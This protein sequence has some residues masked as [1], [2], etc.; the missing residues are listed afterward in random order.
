LWT[1]SERAQAAGNTDDTNWAPVQSALAAR[2]HTVFAGHVHHYVQYHRGGHEYY[3]LATTGGGSQL[4]GVPYGEFDHVTWVTMESD[5]PRI[6]HV[7]LDGVLAPDV[8]TEESIAR[9]RKF[10]AEARFHVDPVLLE[11]SA[12]FK[13]A[14]L[15][16]TILNEFDDEIAVEAR[17]AG[18]PMAGLTLDPPVVVATL[19]PHDSVEATFRVEFA[20]PIDME[21]FRNVVVNVRARTTTEPAPLAVEQSLPVLID[22]RHRYPRL[23]VNVDGDLDEWAGEVESFSDAPTTYGASDQWQGRGDGSV[24]FRV[25]HDGE[26][27]YFGGVVTDDA[28]VAGRD[29][30]LFGI[31]PRPASDRNAEPRLGDHGVVVRLNPA[32][33]RQS[34]TVRVRRG[35]RQ[36]A[37]DL[38]NAQVAIVPGDQGYTFEI[39]V[40]ASILSDAQGTDGNSFQ[41]NLVMLDIDEQGDEDVFILWRPASDWRQSN[42]N[43]AHFYAEE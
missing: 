30:L 43:Y 29:R 32:P 25:A 10:L 31:D 24:S 14:E 40:P 12:D 21:L 9:F 13:S 38:P 4:R 34:A 5:G 17:P 23:A 6:A 35:R 2:P 20:R 37:V 18:L 11:P 8:V 19:P 41:L 22:H 7:L 28:V 1:Y 33:D 15:R 39:A 27:L 42:T 26:F 36:S 16:V 3:Q